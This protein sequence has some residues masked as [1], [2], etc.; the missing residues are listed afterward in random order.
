MLKAFC[1][2]FLSLMPQKMEVE[3]K[4]SALAENQG[5]E[6][7]N[8]KTLEEVQKF[9]KKELAALFKQRKN[10]TLW[11]KYCGE[12][13]RFASTG[14][15]GNPMQQGLKLDQYICK[16]RCNKKQRLEAIFATTGLE[17]ETNQIRAIIRACVEQAE[18]VNMKKSKITDFFGV[19][20]KPKAATQNQEESVNNYDMSETSHVEN[21]EVVEAK[22]LSQE[23]VEALPLQ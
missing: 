5:K 14:V 3:K 1:H 21:V 18:S 2:Y 11:C 19:T 4:D 22:E 12:Q 15:G 16:G 17:E 6:L 10:G 8:C 23:A 9:L 7:T 13:Q 20:K